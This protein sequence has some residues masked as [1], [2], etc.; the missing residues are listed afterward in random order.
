MKL[1]GRKESYRPGLF[2]SKLQPAE[3]GMSIRGGGLQ[4]ESVQ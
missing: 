4:S 3:T 1:P 2:I